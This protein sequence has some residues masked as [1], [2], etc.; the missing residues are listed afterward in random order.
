MTTA[1][2]DSVLPDAQEALPSLS[3]ATTCD[4]GVSTTD[5]SAATTDLGH[6]LG[7]D[8]L[9]ESLHNRLISLPSPTDDG[10]DV[11]QLVSLVARQPISSGLP[12][13]SLPIVA[14]PAVG[15]DVQMELHR[16]VVRTNRLLRLL[17]DKACVRDLNIM[18]Q[19]IWRATGEERETA[20]YPYTRF[21]SILADSCGTEG[22][23]ERLRRVSRWVAEFLDPGLDFDPKTPDKLQVL[24][25]FCSALLT[26]LR[27]HAPLWEELM[28]RF[29]STM[30]LAFPQS[31]VAAGR[32][33]NKDREKE[34]WFCNVLT[35]TVEEYVGRHGIVV[36]GE[37]CCTFNGPL[38]P[39]S[40]VTLKLSDVAFKEVSFKTTLTF[41]DEQVGSIPFL[42]IPAR[43]T[44][45]FQLSDLA[46][47]V[48]NFHFACNTPEYAC[49]GRGRIDASGGSMML[50][51]ELA[52]SPDGAVTIA[53]CRVSSISARAMR[54]ETS[55]EPA[56]S[57]EKVLFHGSLHVLSAF[58]SI[59]FRAFGSKLDDAVTS[60]LRG[61]I[62]EVN[63]WLGHLWPLLSEVDDSVPDA[64][65][66]VKIDTEA[67]GGAGVA[68]AP[69][70]LPHTEATAGGEGAREGPAEGRKTA[71]RSYDEAELGA[72]RSEAGP[73]EASHAA[74]AAAS[75]SAQ[76]APYLF[77]SCGASAGAALVRAHVESSRE[78]AAA[79]DGKRARSFRDELEQPGAL[80]RWKTEVRRILESL[81]PR[82]RAA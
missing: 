51:L 5:F 37:I 79:T 68:A 43:R 72:C 22:G 24:E 28:A 16:L 47:T 48:P 70:Q 11:G 23:R 62:A 57:F 78:A 59:I 3:R 52:A 56:G 75:A 49:D 26:S 32:D 39:Y 55:A 8:Q 21:I 33:S 54:I 31:R 15:E 2:L 1:T 6:C 17:D 71:K 77:D 7:T 64:Q 45:S 27:K 12:R 34:R 82:M 30:R 38:P 76:P 67:E 73:T 14:Q 29:G 20:M 66:D 63:G 25:N 9:D 4:L 46:F 81:A 50:S 53:D 58:P 69:T 19:A 36:G 44:L 10:I 40:E 60:S 42:Q 41:S 74:A 18:V 61:G 65:P 80:D 13:V 35:S